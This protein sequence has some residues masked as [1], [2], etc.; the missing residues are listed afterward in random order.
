MAAQFRTVLFEVCSGSSEDVEKQLRAFS[1]NLDVETGMVQVHRDDEDN[2]KLALEMLGCRV[3][4]VV[5]T[6]KLG[7]MPIAA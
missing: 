5:E 6:R 1:D 2:V 7:T 4:S 3:L